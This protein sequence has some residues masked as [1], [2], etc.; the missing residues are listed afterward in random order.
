MVEQQAPRFVGNSTHRLLEL[1]VIALNEEIHQWQN[2]FLPLAQ[3]RNENRDDRQAIVKVLPELALALRLLQVAVGSGND[4]HIHL[5]V[6][7]PAYPANHLVLKNPQQLGL[8]QRRQLADFVE[9]EGPAIGHFE[10]ALLHLLGIG[11]RALLVPEELGFHQRFRDRRA[12][13]G[14]EWPLLPGA[15]VMDRLGDQIF[16]SA[17]FALDQNRRCFAGRYLANEAHQFGHL[18]RGTDHLVITTS[19]AHFTPQRLHLGAEPGRLQ[20]VLDRDL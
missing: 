10:Q 17:A 13:N 7:D 20:R 3:R 12:V 5:H 8:Q 14:D 18:R 11:E 6:A 19:S 4:A 16:S 1:S 15:L 2:I 9:E